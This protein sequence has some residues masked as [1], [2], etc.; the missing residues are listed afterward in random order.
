MVQRGEVSSSSPTL[1]IYKPF[2][3]FHNIKGYAFDN[4]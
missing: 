2:H 1:Q 4:S 3:P